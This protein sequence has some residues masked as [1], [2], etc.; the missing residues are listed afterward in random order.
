[1]QNLNDAKIYFENP[2]V[3]RLLKR[4]GESGIRGPTGMTKVVENYLDHDMVI[5][6]SIIIKL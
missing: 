2:F 1:V 3:T 6:I 5:S 4:D